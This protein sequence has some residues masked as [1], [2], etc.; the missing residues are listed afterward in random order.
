[1]AQEEGKKKLNPGN[2][3]VD[4]IAKLRFKRAVFR[5]ISQYFIK[6]YLSENVQIMISP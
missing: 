6:I 3:I 2:P 1:M 4:E 5:R